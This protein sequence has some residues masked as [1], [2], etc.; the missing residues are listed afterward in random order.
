LKQA[1]CIPNAVRGHCLIKFQFIQKRLQRPNIN[2]SAGVYQDFWSI[3]ANLKPLLLV[4]EKFIPTELPSSGMLVVVA[5]YLG[6]TFE[7]NRNRICN[8][9]CPTFCRWKNVI[10]FDFDAAELMTD[11]A[12]PM[13][14]R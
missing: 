6:M 12:T 2:G 13:A 14:L 5:M 8:I 4:R 10:R 3:F 11:T 9:V 1:A 7:A